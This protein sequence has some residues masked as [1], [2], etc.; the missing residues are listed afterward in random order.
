MSRVPSSSPPA[1]TAN[2]KQVEWIQFPSIVAAAALV[3]SNDSSFSCTYQLFRLLGLRNQPISIASQL[4][5]QMKYQ[6]R[7]NRSQRWRIT[8]TNFMECR[9]DSPIAPAPGAIFLQHQMIFACVGGVN[10]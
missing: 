8:S 7:R 2:D 4:A 10:N 6:T 9:G 3:V 5:N 1:A